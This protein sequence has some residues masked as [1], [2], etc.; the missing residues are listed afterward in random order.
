MGIKL[1]DFNTDMTV[2]WLAPD[3]EEGEAVLQGVTAPLDIW[4][5]QILYVL[6]E[7]QRRQVID[8]IREMT[9]KENVKRE[10]QELDDAQN[11]FDAEHG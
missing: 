9:E 10:A 6:S 11:E 1:G 8:T 4:V 7:D 2:T 3:N 5:G